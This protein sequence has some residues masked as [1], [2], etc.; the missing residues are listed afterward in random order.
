[1]L[2]ER[3]FGEAYPRLPGLGCVGVRKIGVFP[4]APSCTK[5]GRG[6]WNFCSHPEAKTQAKLEKAADKRSGCAGASTPK[7]L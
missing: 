6:L 2:S 5:A 1:M 7:S 3:T 4:N